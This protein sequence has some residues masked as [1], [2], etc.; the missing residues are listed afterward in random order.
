MTGDPLKSR[1][2][3]EARILDRAGQDP[4]FRR[5]LLAN[6]QATIEAALGVK[7]PSGIRLNILEETDGQL[8]LVLPAQSAGDG[9]LTDSELA[10]V[11]GGATSFGGKAFG[12]LAAKARKAAEAG[13]N[14]ETLS[15]D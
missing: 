14:A 2:E 9:E 11:S 8:Y 15:N 3:A 12:S 13:H 5:R 7:V 1:R 6:P 4:E 10:A